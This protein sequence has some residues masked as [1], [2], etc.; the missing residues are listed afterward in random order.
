MIT[1]LSDHNLIVFSRKLSKNRYVRPFNKTC[2]LLKI[3]KSEI[4]NLETALNEINWS[5]QL[6]H[7]H[8]DENCHFQKILKGRN[9]KKNPALAQ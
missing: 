1:G 3:H 9:Q 7:D 2:E 5:D 6:L 8:I 4:N